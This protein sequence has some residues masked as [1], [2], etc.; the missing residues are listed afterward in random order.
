MKRGIDIV[1]RT[2]HVGARRRVVTLALNHDDPAHDFLSKLKADDIN[3]FRSIRTRIRAVADYDRYENQSTF[4]YVGRGVYEFKRRG[5]RL[6][7]F[8][9]EI[10]GADQLILCTNG[11]T[12]NTRKGQQADILK[13]ADRKTAYF[14]AKALP[15]TTLTLDE[16]EP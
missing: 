11:G 16:D 12:K 3:R 6:Y 15:D 10:D 14:S 5:I 1:L 8:Y 2:L 13:A 4:R 7:A 9:D